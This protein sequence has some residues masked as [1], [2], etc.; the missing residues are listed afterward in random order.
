MF[1]PEG[2]IIALF[3]IFH[4]S[5]SWISLTNFLLHSL[6]RV[7]VRRNQRFGRT[8]ARQRPRSSLRLDQVFQ[9]E[10]QDRADR[11]AGRRAEQAD[12]RRPKAHQEVLRRLDHLRGPRLALSSCFFSSFPVNE[13][14]LPILFWSL[15]FHF[16]TPGSFFFSG[17]SGRTR[18]LPLIF[19]RAFPICSTCH[20]ATM[21]REYTDSQLYIQQLYFQHLFQ[22]R[23]RGW[24]GRTPERNYIF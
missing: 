12:H 15:L 8:P 19:Q 7:P 1:R 2:L 24:M 5:P 21:Y 17:C 11:E 14:F 23:R 9:P 3:S 18:Q 16:L 22:V 6:V 13:T 20:K 10:L 4:L